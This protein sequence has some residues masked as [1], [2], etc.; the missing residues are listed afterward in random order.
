MTKSA[1]EV[2]ELDAAVDRALG[3]FQSTQEADGSWH[4][5]YGGPVFLL[6][7]MV[8]AL[9]IMDKPFDEET[10][11]GFIDYFRHTQN[12]DG[13]WP[14]HTSGASYVYTTAICYVALRLL[15]IPAEDRDMQRGREWL[16]QQG[17]PT[18]AAPWG[19]FVLALLNLYDYD[20]V[21]PVPPELWL[22]PKALPIHPARF[23]CHN[24]MVYLPMSY[25]YGIRAR[26]AASPLI[27]DLRRELYSEPY[28]DID[29]R[30]TQTDCASPDSYV[31]LSGVSRVLNRGLNG[32][33]RIAVTS[34]R[35]RACDFVLDQIRREDDNTSF[36]CIGPVSKVFNMLAWHFAK[37]GGPQVTAHRRQLPEYMWKNDHGIHM[38]GYNS[39][40]LWDTTLAAQAIIAARPGPQYGAMLTRVHDYVDGNQVD[41]DVSDRHICFRNASKG[42]W[43]FSDRK[44]GWPVSDCTA[45]GL[46]TVL[47]LASW[48]AHP[49]GEDRLRDA[50]RFMLRA[51][52]DDGG[53]PS[54]EKARAPTWLEALNPSMAFSG[55]MID[56]SYVEC[57]SACIQALHHYRARASD[58]ALAA[59]ID[60]AIDRGRNFLLEQQREDGSWFGSWAICFTYG[61]WFGISGLRAAGLG[62]SDPAI[63]RAADF[64]VSRQLPDGG[65]GETIESCRTGTY[66]STGG[67]Q[68]VMTGWAI[69][70]LL[71]S[72]LADSEAVRTATRFLC[73][74]QN[75]D[76]SW[77]DESIAGVFNRTCGIHYGNY[78][79]I[80]GLW[81]L[82]AARNKRQQMTDDRTARQGVSDEHAQP[83]S[84][85]DESR[86]DQVN[87]GCL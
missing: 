38:Q 2:A 11:Q 14:L 69:L 7:T 1:A 68:T 53:W 42:G 84:Q 45:E 64:L 82:A 81:A 59:E 70:G 13:G 58:P 74:R 12:G 9:H 18:R 79:Q 55:I 49:V 20:G 39:S 71:Q 77:P 57:T 46:K 34:L 43:P 67:G 65:W 54:Y 47:L 4:G 40:K 78:R 61:T 83:G 16:A 15:G 5:D 37:P 36:I 32:Y 10:N 30:G 50:V 75:T 6:P 56:Y 76:G 29:W 60:T 23:Y 87:V 17:G 62:E 3:H 8:I 33:E 73:G 80:F 21:M 85:V 28:S 25:L 31:P 24:R 26:M 22:L 27:K 72:D 52:N 48:A 44:H 35:Q 19:K 86:Q 41:T 66:H 51:Q 63:R